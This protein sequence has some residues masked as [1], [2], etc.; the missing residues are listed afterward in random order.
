MRHEILVMRARDF[1]NSFVFGRLPPPQY[2][3]PPIWDEVLELN[4]TPRPVKLKTLSLGPVVLV[5]TGAAEGVPLVA[6][7][8]QR[9]G[10]ETLDSFGVDTIHFPDTRS[11][12]ARV[13]DERRWLFRCLAWT[14]LPSDEPG[15][16]VLGF[17]TGTPFAT[18]RSRLRNLVLT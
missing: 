2:R 6:Y 7:Q 3:S 14:G 9:E 15:S 12:R 10:L 18:V 8:L 4:G 13:S 16:P 11:F 1:G 5:Y 17:L